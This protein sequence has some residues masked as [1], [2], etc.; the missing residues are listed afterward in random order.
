VPITN[1][2]LRVRD[3]NLASLVHPVNWRSTIE[4]TLSAQFSRQQAI[5]RTAPC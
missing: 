1:L 2:D 5:L 3:I 4:G